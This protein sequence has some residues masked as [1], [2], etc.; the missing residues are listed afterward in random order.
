[1]RSKKGI[2]GIIAAV[3]TGIGIGML[4][5]PDKGKQTRKDLLDKIRSLIK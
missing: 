4:I 1:M 5:A 3:L 2:I